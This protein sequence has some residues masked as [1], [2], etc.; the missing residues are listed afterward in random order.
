MA[1]TV[2]REALLI[3]GNDEIFRSTV[4]DSLGFAGR[5]QEARNG[6]GEAIGL[7]G[8][9][10]SILIAVDYLSRHARIGISAVGTHLHLSGAFVTIEINKLVKAALIEKTPDPEDGRRV[11]LKVTKRGAALLSS[12]NALQ[13]EVNDAIFGGLSREEFQQLSATM[14]KLVGGVEEAL[15]L[16]H[17]RSQQRQQA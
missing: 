3:G 14:R 5:L 8:P 7:T 13:Q 4:H 2:T 10:Y 15:A 17:L 16:L 12:L 11:I 9:A 1:Y 6:L